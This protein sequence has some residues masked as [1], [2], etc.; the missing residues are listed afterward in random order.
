MGGSTAGVDRTF[1]TRPSVFVSIATRGG[2][3]R[4]AG[5]SSHVR[6]CR[7]SVTVTLLKGRH[8]L[9]VHRTHVRLVSLRCQWRSM[10]KL[11]RTK[12]GAAKTLT[13]VS[14]FGGNAYLGAS[15]GA[16]SVKVPL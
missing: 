9:G 14:R 10:F 2:L 13:Q 12:V 11:R 4:P 15:T 1:K 7:G 6:W 16:T 5:V 8:V 3:L